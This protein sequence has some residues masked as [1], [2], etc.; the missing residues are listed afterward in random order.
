MVP[1]PQRR[2]GQDQGCT[3]DS[4]LFS[5]CTLLAPGMHPSCGS[6]NSEGPVTG[7]AS[8]ADVPFA[9][10]ADFYCFHFFTDTLNDK[11]DQAI[12]L[13]AGTSETTGQWLGPHPLLCKWLADCRSPYQLSH[14]ACLL[15]R[16]LIIPLPK[17]PLILY[18]SLQ[19]QPSLVFPESCLR[20]GPLCLGHQGLT[21]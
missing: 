4:P 5:D 18:N 10:S 15:P 3:W 8:E 13:P 16:W 14:T 9:T 2:Q 6:A 21:L 17:H 7:D 12:T 19:A 1:T 20:A 11:A